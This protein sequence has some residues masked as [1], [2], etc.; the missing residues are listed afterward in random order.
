MLESY[1]TDDALTVERFGRGFA[2]LD[3]GTHGALLDAANFVRALQA[4]QGLQVGCPEEI[5]FRRGWIDPADLAMAVQRFEKND[6]G[7][8]LMALLDR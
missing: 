5:A 2:W 1:L 4:R 8:Y 6:Y 7:Q 3:T